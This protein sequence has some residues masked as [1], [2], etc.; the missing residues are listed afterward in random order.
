MW[1]CRNMSD[2]QHKI[3]PCAG[4]R[5]SLYILYLGQR[6]TFVWPP[7]QT[8]HRT[9]IMS[10]IA[11]VGLK[12][13]CIMQTNTDRYPLPLIHHQSAG[14]DT[15]SIFTPM[16]V[17]EGVITS[18]S[19]RAVPVLMHFLLLLSFFLLPSLLPLPAFQ[20]TLSFSNLI[21]LSIQINLHPIYNSWIINIS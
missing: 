21:C 6:V 7:Y 14:H 8:H 15:V 20:L 4:L 19:L 11:A 2:K 17:E 16:C 3:P 10:E 18:S 13:D 1:K 12:H 5:S 9:K